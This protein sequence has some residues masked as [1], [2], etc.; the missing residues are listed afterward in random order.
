MTLI[1]SWP[2]ALSLTL[3][4]SVSLLLPCLIL[5]FHLRHDPEHDEHA[6]EYDEHEHD[7]HEHAYEYD[8]HERDEHQG[9]DKQGRWSKEGRNRVATPSKLDPYPRE[10]KLV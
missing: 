5:Y 2:W 3:G 7:E 6:H 1:W 8:E 4:S 10:T 9:W